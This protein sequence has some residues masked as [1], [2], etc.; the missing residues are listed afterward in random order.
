MFDVSDKPKMVERA[1]L[2]SVCF[3]RDKPEE[4]QALLDELGELV[5]TLGIPVVDSMVVRAPRPNAGLLVGSGKAEEICEHVKTHEVDVIIFDNGLSPSQQRKWES[6]SKQCVI[7]R[8]EVILDI[9]ARRALTREATL[10]VALARMEYSLPRLTRAWTHLSR[11]SG[12]GGTGGRGEGET[13]LEVDRRIVRRRIDRLKS[14]L[15]QVRKQRAT[16]RKSRMRIPLPMAAIVGYTNA[17][18]SSLLKKMTNADVFIEDKLFATLDT[19][20]RKVPLPNGQDLLLTDTVGFVRSLPHGLIESFKATLEEA[21]LADFLIHVLDASNP[22]VYTFHK[23]T[24]EVLHELGAE[25]KQ[26]VT[27]FNKIDKLE[28]QTTIIHLRR[29]FPDAV[30]ISIHSGEGMDGLLHTLADMLNSLVS[31]VSLEL[32]NHRSDLVSR[33]HQNGRVLSTEYVDDVVRIE[34]IIPNRL[35]EQLARIKH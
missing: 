34:A 26:I 27:V 33:I 28:D 30:F 7:D 18:K 16:Q 6:L 5:E 15:V 13:Q 22:E 3:G 25:Q 20:T 8:E 29:N 2:V 19:T 11:Q 12:A 14:E 35:K 17:G 32:P 4:A 1:L 24:L 21:V 10:Q 9:F 31:H 23:T